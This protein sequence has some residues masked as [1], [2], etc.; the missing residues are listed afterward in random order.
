M[1]DD[2]NRAQVRAIRKKLIDGEITE[3]EARDMGFPP[4]D[5]TKEKR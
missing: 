3:A 2:L 4:A 1:G 5:P